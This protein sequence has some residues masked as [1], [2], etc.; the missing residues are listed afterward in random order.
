MIREI[1]RIPASVLPKG[2]VLYIILL[3]YFIIQAYRIY[4]SNAL[5][6]NP[7]AH[8]DIIFYFSKTLSQFS[9]K[10]IFLQTHKTF[11]YLVP[12]LIIIEIIYSSFKSFLNVRRNYKIRNEE[13]EELSQ[14]V[15]DV[16]IIS[17]RKNR[18]IPDIKENIETLIEQITI[19]NQIKILGSTGYN[20][21]A[22]DDSFLNNNFNDFTGEIKVML[23]NPGITDPNNF[24]DI[25]TDCS[26]EDFKALLTPEVPKEIQNRAFDIGT[27]CDKY[28]EEIYESIVYLKKLREAGRF[29]ELKF[30]QGPL[31]WKLIISGQ[32]MWLQHYMPR[33]HVHKCPVYGIYKTNPDTTIYNS[34]DMIYSRLWNSEFTITYPL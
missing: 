8:F 26:F 11:F 19:S 2:V 18:D 23:L 9:W 28:I 20:T 29:I 13:H 15:Y 5:P 7:S 21:F 30:H 1:I 33:I 17:F 12:I 27:T 4:I 6:E 32:Y 25:G 31:I 14:L 24:N 3:I 22:N 16:G 34:F 10:N